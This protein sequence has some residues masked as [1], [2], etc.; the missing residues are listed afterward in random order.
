RASERRNTSSGW[1]DVV[2]PVMANSLH[3]S[4]KSHGAPS[5]SQKISKTSARK[6]AHALRDVCSQN[7]NPCPVAGLCDAG[8]VLKEHGSR[9]VVTCA[10]RTVSR[11]R[12][13]RKTGSRSS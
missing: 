2:G 8:V 6:T 4:R 11:D 9:W 3:K 12:Y 5:D 10:S 13:E 1:S 7:R